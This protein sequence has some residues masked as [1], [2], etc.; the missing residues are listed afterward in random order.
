MSFLGQVRKKALQANRRIV[1]PESSDERVIRAASQILKENLAQVILVGNQ[2]AIMHSA[3]AYEVSLSGVKIVDPY[4][5][6]R[7][8]D[9]VNKLVE[10]RS[11]KGMTPEEAK[12]L[13][14]TDPNFFGAMLVKMGDADGMVSGSAS[15]TANVL[16]AAIQVIGTQPGVKTVSS[17]FIMEL[18]QFKDLFGS[19]LVFGDCSV[20]PVPTSEQLADIATSAAETAVRIAGINPRVALLTFSTKGSAKHE[21]VDRIIEAGRILRE[22]KV[23]FRFDDELQADAALV[24][25]VGE[26]KA[27]LSDVSGNAN[28]LIFPTLSAGNIGYKLVQRLAGANAYGPIIQGL[29]APVNDLSRGCSVED[30]VVLTAITSAQ[31]CIDC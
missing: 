7:L 21:C 20:I 13:L 9:Y 3:K 30:I 25:S 12:K 29:N 11:K 14:Q 16:R 1:L 27:P 19:I 2:E 4:N 28:V 5:F 26:I 24:K 10:L 15:P 6:E 8:N 18:S 22:R 17:V 31:A 23:Q